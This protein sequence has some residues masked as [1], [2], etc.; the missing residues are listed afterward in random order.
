MPILHKFEFSVDTTYVLEVG[1]GYIRFLEN[2]AYVIDGSGPSLYAVATPYLD[3][4]VA[5]LQYKQINDVIWVTHPNYPPYKLSRFADDDWTFEEIEFDVPP[6]LDENLDDTLTITPSATTGSISLV[7]SDPLFDAAHVGAYWRIGHMRDADTVELAISGNNTSSTIEAKG[8][9]HVRSYGEWTADLIIERQRVSGGDWELIHRLISKNTRNVDV[10]GNDAEN[11]TYRLRVENYVSNTDGRALFETTEAIIRGT[12]IITAVTDSENATAT[13]V[14]PLYSNGATYFWSEG[15]FSEYRGFPRAVTFHEGRI[16]YGGTRYQPLHIWGSV[17]DSFDDFER[18]TGDDMSVVLQLGS[19]EYN[20][21]QWLASKTDLLVGI[22]GAEWRVR[23]DRN[24]NIITP[25]RFDLKEQSKYGSEYVQPI[26]IGGQVIFVERRGRTLR[27]MTY[28]Y[29]VERYVSDTNLNLLAEHRGEAGVV[30]LAFQRVPVPTIW[31][32]MADGTCSALTYDRAQNVTGWHK[33]VTDGL[34]KSVVSTY[35]GPDTEDEVYFI[36]ERIIGTETKQFIERFDS[37]RWTA[38]EDGFFVDCGLTYDGSPTTSF[39]GMGHLAGE[40]I[41]V[42]ADGVVYLDIE[43]EDNGTFELP[44]G[45]PAASIV[46]AGLRYRSTLSPFRFD[47]DSRLGVHS[48]QKKRIS[49]VTMRLFRSLGMKVT[50]DGQGVPVLHPEG[51]NAAPA[52]NQP[53]FGQNRPEDAEV[54]WA[55]KTEYDPTIVITQDNPLPLS[56]MSINVSYEVSSG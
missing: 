53:L 2:D 22:A 32:V 29:E 26:T 35:G 25:S 45:A 44:S 47:A 51:A 4:D 6:L 34:F 17:T 27:E 23:G 31:C 43:V 30:Q 14:D 38:K 21:V 52:D 39:S 12:V 1:A 48:G 56:V 24:G 11:Y 5:T 46:H 49:N 18:G 41:D 15:A 54:R 50:V 40:L 7:A 16:W 3:A 42:L 9:W 28:S 8:Y 33:H 13:V 19:S 55:G 36:V 37:N 10:E 20:A